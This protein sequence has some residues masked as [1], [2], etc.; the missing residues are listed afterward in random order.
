[1]V[2]KPHPNKKDRARAGNIFGKLRILRKV[3]NPKGVYGVSWQVQCSCGSPPFRI[4]EQ[5]LFRK[6]NPKTHCGCASQTIITKFKREYS[7]WKMM[8]RRCYFD[9]HAS[10]DYYGAIGIKVCDDWRDGGYDVPLEQNIKAFGSFLKH[11]GPAPSLKHTLDRKNPFGN[12]EP[13]NVRWATREQQANNQRKHY[14][15]RRR[16]KS[17]AS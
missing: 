7:I 12:Y 2:K 17:D 15:N 6:D 1:M 9:T 10:W 14:I 8:N 4:R 3:R 16:D 5:Y 11:V 13:G